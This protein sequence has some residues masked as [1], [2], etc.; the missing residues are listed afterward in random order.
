MR[1]D[2]SLVF[3]DTSVVAGMFVRYGTDTKD[4]TPLSDI[5]HRSP[6]SRLDRFIIEE[7]PELQRVVALDNG[8]RNRHYLAGIHGDFPK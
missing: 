7:P 1:P 6:R 8:T 3:R 4:S 5:E 2:P